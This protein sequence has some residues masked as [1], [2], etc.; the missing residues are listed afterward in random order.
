[1]A[2]QKPTVTLGYSMSKDQ[3]CVEQIQGNNPTVEFQPREFEGEDAKVARIGMWLSEAEATV[4][5]RWADLIVRSYRLD[6]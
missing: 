1:M 2:G 6:A 5:G 3:Y 4:L